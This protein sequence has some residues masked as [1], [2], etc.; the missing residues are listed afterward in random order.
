MTTKAIQR[1]DAYLAQAKLEKKI[2]QQ[3]GVEW[4]LKK[5]FDEV[6]SIEGVKGGI[7]ADEMGLGKTIVMSGLIVSNFVKHTLIV[8]PLALIDQWTSVFATTMNHVPMV[9]HGAAKQLIGA[10]ELAKAPIVI[11]TYGHLAMRSTSE[12]APNLITLQQWDRVIFDEAHHLR[13]MN[14]RVHMGALDL[15][16]KVKWMVTGTPVQNRFSD[17]QALCVVMGLSSKYATS[18]DNVPEIVQH[19]MLRRRKDEVGLELPKLERHME[20]VEWENSAEKQLAEDM[21]SLLQFSNVN[22][23]NVDSHITGLDNEILATLIR[24]RQLCIYPNL[25]AP[26]AEKLVQMGVFEDKTACHAA[27]SHSSKMNAVEKAI[28]NRK[29]NQRGK[30]IFCHYRSEIDELARRLKDHKMNVETFDGR[31]THNQRAE[32]LNGTCDAL[33]LQIQTGCEGL[34]LQQFSEIYFVSPHW[35]PAVEDQAVARCH[36]IGQTVPIDVFRFQ[37]EGF[38]DDQSSISLDIHSGNV[39]HTKRQTS[40]ALEDEVETAKTGKVRRIKPVF[41]DMDELKG[42]AKHK[43]TKE[44]YLKD[45]YVVDENDEDTDS[46]M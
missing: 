33:I 30:L 28:A 26:H 22:K 13:N 45:G 23:R 40:Q 34:N 41:T 9:Y 17:F 29:D 16:S 7:I 32:I 8:L 11:T 3:E 46:D 14:T 4:C 2:H 44:G 12:D 10:E 6:P 1:F 21:H 38:D 20:V 27:L 5:E 31:T 35:N 42:V 18:L 15:K 25:L 24:A 37:M 36:R 43:K 19:Y 39:Q